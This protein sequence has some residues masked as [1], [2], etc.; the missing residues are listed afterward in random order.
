MAA[1]ATARHALP[2]Y[3]RDLCARERARERG[4]AGVCREDSD[5]IEAHK[6]G[7][8]DGGGVWRAQGRSHADIVCASPQ[9]D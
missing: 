6:R 7:E 5:R 3:L 2:L 4:K 1:V 9:A 8:G